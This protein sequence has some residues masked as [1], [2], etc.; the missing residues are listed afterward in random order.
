M[1]RTSYPCP[2]CPFCGSLLTRATFLTTPSSRPGVSH[3]FC[4]CNA[5]GCGRDWWGYWTEYRPV[6]AYPYVRWTL[7]VSVHLVPWVHADTIADLECYR[8]VLGGLGAEHNDYFPACC[9]FPKSCSAYDG[10]VT[11]GVGPRRTA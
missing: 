11:T 3:A 10:E 7:R 2:P 5:R 4:G 6:D 9:R 1:T 8:T